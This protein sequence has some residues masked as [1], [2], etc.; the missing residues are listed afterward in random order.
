MEPH[1]PEPDASYFLTVFLNLRK[2]IMVNSK[3]IVKESYSKTDSR[4]E[5]IPV[6]LPV[7]YEPREYQSPEAT[8][9]I[10]LQPNFSTRVRANERLMVVNVAESV[11]FI[12][13]E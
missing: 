1:D 13:I 5:S 3:N 4:V 2:R 11:G 9:A 8:T 12:S 10:F 6:E 7:I